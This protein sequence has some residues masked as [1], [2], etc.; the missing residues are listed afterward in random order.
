M[1]RRTTDPPISWLM[2]LA[3]DRPELI[4]LA[5]GF[6]DDA[7]L[8]V[9]KTQNLLNDILG[10]QDLSL[11]ALQYGTTCGNNELRRLTCQ[12]LCQMDLMA[13]DELKS[14]TKPDLSIFSPERT[15]ITNGSQQLLYL[16][17]EALCDPGDIILVE[18]P[19]YFVF[20]G[21]TQSH[22]LKCRG[23][24]MQDDGIS[25]EKLEY[26]L[27]DLKKKGQLKRLK[28]LYS[29]SYFQNP[30]GITTSCVKKRGIARLLREYEKAAGHPIYLLEDGAYRELRFAGADVP[31]AL[32]LEGSSERIVYAGTYS[33]PFATGIKIGYGIIPEP[34]FS[35]IK[36]IKGNHDFGSASFLQVLLAKALALGD[37]SEHVRMLRERYISKSNVMIRA[38]RNYFPRFTHYSEPKGGLYIWAR[39]PETMKTGRSS[40]LFNDALNAGVL[41]VPGGYCYAEDASRIVSDSEMRLSF[42]QANE[43]QMQEG[44]KRLGTVIHKHSNCR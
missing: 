12:R 17:V 33:K 6:T 28:F 24:T 34:L 8:P 9:Q 39:L 27:M 4:S 16:L 11:R 21:I 37:Y 41:Y 26:V 15:L 20:L 35:V 23:I 1:G 25:L 3:L 44:I 31:S 10:S 38:M 2:Q 42:G 29:V 5:A 14:E 13:I 22:N 7:T 43:E 19:T 18:D 40:P 36:R 32:A 30:S